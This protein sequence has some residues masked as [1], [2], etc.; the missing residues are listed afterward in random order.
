MAGRVEGKV[1]LITGGARG[2]GRADALLLAREGAKIIITDILDGSEIAKAVGGTYFPHDVSDEDQWISVINKTMEIYGK[3]DIL[4]NNAAIVI[5]GNIENTSLQDYRKVFSV[6]SDGTFLGCKHAIPLM[7]ENGGGSII[8]MASL[9]ALRAF[10]DVIAYTAAKG[11]IRSLTKVVAR[12][13]LDHDYKIR[14]NSIYPAAIDTPMLGHVQRPAPKR[15]LGAPDDV[16]NMVLY[17]ASDE[18]KFVTAAEFV[19]DNG[20]C[21]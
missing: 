10:P 18:S 21:A 4:V 13:C 16:A 15:P 7:R 12:H 11:A 17:L 9:T 5:S 1:A 8:N 19:V 20:Y 6:S 3:L 2:L 14:C